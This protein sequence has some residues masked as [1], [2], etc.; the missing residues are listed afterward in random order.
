[1]TAAGDDYADM[2]YDTIK[3]AEMIAR[4]RAHGWHDAAASIAAQTE[5]SWGVRSQ[6]HLLWALAVI[7]KVLPAPGPQQGTDRDAVEKLLRAG[8]ARPSP[9]DITRHLAH[10]DQVN[11]TVDHL[12]ENILKKGKYA[13]VAHRTRTLPLSV[14]SDI[15]DEAAHR[16]GQA[17]AYTEETGLTT[18]IDRMYLILN[19]HAAEGDRI[20]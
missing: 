4:C 10:C 2:V 8:G 20:P 7:G 11:R 12:A 13:T 16:A 9:D 17:V 5:A 3:A 19:H 6:H 14:L 1:V 15:V 18:A